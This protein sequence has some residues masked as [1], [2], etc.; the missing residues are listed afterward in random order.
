MASLLGA[1]VETTVTSREVKSWTRFVIRHLGAQSDVMGHEHRFAFDQNMI[2]VKLPRIEHVDRGEGYDEIASVRVRSADG[3]PRDYEI[4]KV[5][6]E[7]S[8]GGRLVFPLE[9][10]SQSPNAFDLFSE[11]EQTHLN[12]VS[13]QHQLIAERAFEYWIRIVRWTCDDFSLGRDRGEGFHSG[14]G[15]RLADVETGKHV[16]IPTALFRATSYRTVSL[17]EWEAIQQSLSAGL[18]PPAYIEHKHDAEEYVE[19]GDYRRALVDLA[20]ACELFLRA[21]VVRN[22]P[23]ELNEKFKKFIEDGNINQYVNQFFQEIINEIGNRQFKKIQ[24]ELRSLFG[25]RNDL[26]HL[27]KA[28]GVNRQL[29]E[30]FLKTT[31]DLLALEP[32]T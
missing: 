19:R 11:A 5:D 20:V 10:L 14:W 6:V 12:E 27:G 32:L 15:T 13:S 9:V 26:L 17:Q 22:L 7:V 16:W 30:R 2:T 21:M 25:R 18:Y 23:A 31:K 24:P 4:L 28:D 3:K 1:I 29:C 8:R